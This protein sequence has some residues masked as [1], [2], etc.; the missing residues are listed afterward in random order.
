VI[1]RKRLLLLVPV[2]IATVTA[3]W[4][5]EAAAQRRGYR[6]PVRSVFVGARFGYPIYP[7]YPY[8]YYYDPFWWDSYAF[9]YRPFPP[10][11]PYRYD[12]SADLRTQVTPKDAEVYIDGY[13][14]GTV[15][16]FDGVFQRLRLPLGEHEVTIYK[17][18]YHPFREKMLFRP[19]ESYH[20]KQSLRPLAPGE[21]P[22]PRP[23]AVQG[24][25]PP[26]PPIRGG[27][28]GP[29]PRDRNVPADRNADRFGAISVRVQPA[30]AEVL[31]DGEKWDAPAGEPRLLV[32]VSEGTHRVEIRKEGYRTYTSTIRVRA[33]ET[34]PVN[35][36]LAQ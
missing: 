17:E 31:I 2:C 3:L 6:G 29:A 5:A 7:V 24:S 8:P 21:A 15:D 10:Y 1:P 16:D 32:Q 34:V 9:Q 12:V 26:G 4:P 20:I 30:D 27:A 25:Q 33:G 28:P 35:V 14:V 13:L 23:A 22:E 19:Y 36:S 18:G 11:Y